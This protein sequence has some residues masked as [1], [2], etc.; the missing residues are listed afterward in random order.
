MQILINQQPTTLPD[1]DGAT[2]ADALAHWNAQPPYAVAL[3]MRFIPKTQ[4]ASQR[5]QAGDALEII[6]PVTG[7]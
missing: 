6:A 5:L 4:Y 7:G 2:V 1:S 3:N